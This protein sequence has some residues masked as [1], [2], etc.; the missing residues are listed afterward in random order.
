LWTP[1]SYSHTLI[2][3]EGNE[4][5]CGSIGRLFRHSKASHLP[6]KVEFISS[7][8]LTRRHANL[9]NQ[10][11]GSLSAGDFA[12]TM[13]LWVCSRL[14]ARRPTGVSLVRLM[15]VEQGRIFDDIFDINRRASIGYGKLR[16]AADSFQTKGA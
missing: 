14:K 1:D 8:I 2:Q 10:S 5:E 15:Y 7:F 4:D 12:P 6:S 16:F 3:R 9:T 13:I 11:P